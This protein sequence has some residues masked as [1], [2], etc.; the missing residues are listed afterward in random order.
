M[1][2]GTHDSAEGNTSLMDSR[3]IPNLSPQSLHS[4]NFSFGDFIDNYTITNQQDMECQVNFAT[5]Q[6]LRDDQS[7]VA[8]LAGLLAELS[9]ISTAPL[10]FRLEEYHKVLLELFPSNVSKESKT[11]KDRAERALR[12]GMVG[13]NCFPLGWGPCPGILAN[14]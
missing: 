3:K 12:A 4:D 2:P 10:S 11:W 7:R 1:L 8:E 6:V 5:I 9:K 14:H 13:E